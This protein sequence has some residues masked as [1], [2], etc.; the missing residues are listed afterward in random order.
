MSSLAWRF[1]RESFGRAA[2]SS[3]VAT[4]CD[5]VTFE[6]LIRISASPAGVA[7]FLGC[8]L[9]GIVN[10]SLN[11]YWAFGNRRPLLG[12]MLRY[13]A[14]SGTSAFANACLV[15]AQT[16]WLHLPARPA[17]LAARALVF[18]GLTYPLFRRWVFAAG[19]ETNVSLL[20]TANSR[21]VGAQSVG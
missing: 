9:G 14:V 8:V 4:L 12:A 15:L 21:D 19:S 6:G 18:A 17:W 2:I 7:T 16:T 5:Y 3:G 20:T 10:F 13:S 11:R 1:G